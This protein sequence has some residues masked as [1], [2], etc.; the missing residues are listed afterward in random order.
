M[1]VRRRI[2]SG[3]LNHRAQRRVPS[4]PPLYLPAAYFLLRQ[5]KRSREGPSLVAE[6]TIGRVT[7]MVEAC[8]LNLNRAGGARESPRAVKVVIRS[9][10]SE[11][12][13]RGIHTERPRAAKA[14]EQVSGAYVGGH[15][16][17]PHKRELHGVT[18]HVTGVGSGS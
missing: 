18:R 1:R 17:A 4:A 13:C 3:D 14:Q 16:V 7:D 9:L 6:A 12:T 5:D 11:H 2:P 10:E 15:G 8:S